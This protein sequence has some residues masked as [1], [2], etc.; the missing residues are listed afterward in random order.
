MEA[1]RSAERI[2]DTRGY[3]VKEVQREE[4]STPVEGKYEG[5]FDPLKHRKIHTAQHLISACHYHY[6]INVN[7]PSQ[8]NGS[9][10]IIDK[11]MQAEM[12]KPTNLDHVG[13]KGKEDGSEF[14]MHEYDVEV[15]KYMCSLAKEKC[16]KNN[17]DWEKDLERSIYKALEEATIDELCTLK[18]SS[19]NTPSQGDWS[20]YRPLTSGC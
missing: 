10:R 9:L 18:A 11:I 2:L 6:A 20:G 13:L 17:P 14:K 12:K 8:K 1:L 16:R 4:D 15:L 3:R 7:Q 5:L 19:E